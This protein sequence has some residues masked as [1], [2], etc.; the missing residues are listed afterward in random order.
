L[1]KIEP[2]YAFSEVSQEK[3]TSVLEVYGGRNDEKAAD[4]RIGYGCGIFLIGIG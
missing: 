3:H 1:K 2:K 4:R